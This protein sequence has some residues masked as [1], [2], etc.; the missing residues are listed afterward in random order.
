MTGY[1]EYCNLRGI[2]SVL[3]FCSGAA[4]PPE[5]IKIGKDAATAAVKKLKFDDIEITFSKDS[6]RCQYHVR[7][8]WSGVWPAAQAAI[9]VLKAAGIES[10]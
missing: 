10:H 5:T 6:T 9:A 4:L 2:V 1:V 3:L 8:H 7:G